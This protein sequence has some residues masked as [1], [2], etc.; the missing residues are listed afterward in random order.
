VDKFYLIDGSGFIFRAYHALPP[1]QRKDGTPVGA[2]Y[3][4]CN[5]LSKLMTSVD[6]DKILVVF[7]AARKTFRQDI[8]P[9]YKA[10][11]PP[12]PEDLI[13]QFSLIKESCGAFGVSSIE[14]EGFE[15]DD[16]IASLA[17][18]ALAESKQVI[19]VSSD[20]DLMQLVNDNVSLLD[21]IKNKA[22]H[23]DEV[24]E[25]F[26]VPPQ[27]VIDVQALAGDSSDNV[28]GVA[29]IGIKTAAQLI[30]EFG[31]L[32]HLYDNLDHVKQPKR[33]ETLAMDRE[34]AFISKQLVTLKNDIR[35]NIIIDQC[36]ID[37]SN[38]KKRDDF[39][40]EQGFSSLINR[41]N[42][43]YTEDKKEQTDQK[44]APHFKL[45]PP[46][47]VD[48]TEKLEDIFK[49]LS[50][51]RAFAFDTETTSLNTFEA[52]LVGIS[53]YVPEKSYYIP[54]GHVFG[55]QLKKD[56][57][58]HVLK[59]V[60]DDK[61]ILKIAHNLKYDQAI[62]R[63]FGID[64]DTYDDTLLMSYALS[65]N[66]HF[67]NLDTLCEI[68]LH[69]K[70]ITFK[71]IVGEGKNKKTFDQ[72]DIQQ[73][74]HYACE[75]AQTAFA[76]WEIFTKTLHQTKQNLLYQR[77]EKDM[78]YITSAMEY[79][80]ILMDEN[81]LDQL[82][83]EFKTQIEHLEKIIHQKAE[84]EFNIASPKQLG[85]VL[86][87]D[88]KLPGA[89]KTKSGTYSTDNDVLEKLSN[90]GHDIPK[91]I[92]EWR[93]LSKLQTTYI[94][95]LKEAIN[96]DTKRVH[97]SYALTSTSTGRFSSSNPNLQN[98]P[99]RTEDGKKIRAAFIAKPGCKLISFDYSQIELRLLAHIAN[100]ETLKD[101]FK[102]GLDIHQATA[103][104]I[105]DTP[106][107]DVTKEQRYK[108][109]AVNFGIIY[110]ISAFGLAK[111]LNCSNGE[112]ASIIQRYFSTYPGIVEYM[113]KQKT[114]AKE[115]GY[116]ET[117]FKR[118]CYTPDINN[119]NHGLQQFSERQAI[120][121]PLQG[122]CADIIKLAMTKTF[123]FLRENKLQSQL[124]LTVH[125]E[126]IFECPI[127]EIDII[128]KEIKNIMEH[129]T[130]L[131][132][133]LLV[134]TT[135]GDSWGDL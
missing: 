112:A 109:K 90:D 28:P 101:A 83:I 49:T 6:H 62:L 14:M 37:L 48:T 10:H 52:D 127:N 19:I 125:D 88:L 123:H 130:T 72:I 96:K 77:I 56:N 128:Q 86:F 57:V 135:M 8:Y 51:S 11:R 87:D 39:L 89:K 27:K 119:K 73:A 15:A 65:G 64:I 13:P 55:K 47:I 58:F 21:P 124:L 92:Q 1:F 80:G 16:L 126:L 114:F 85:E 59:P 99:V 30:N 38:P 45:I 50:S 79:T 132:V 68:Y 134:D 131:S 100:I 61:S 106:L 70:T 108:A 53:F 116:V 18:Q 84:K 5:M 7:D 113:E 82:G 103:S 121:A 60:F 29:G 40:F 41:L 74:S 133:P 97:T 69:H 26:G 111:Q 120:N 71:D 67:H 33:R 95:G 93:A 46:I 31:S 36:S 115:K 25:K 42:N 66:K 78:A 2:V 76:L 4:F 35:T 98:I 75:D 81:I 110:G 105:Y 23:Y 9:E 22:I 44:N 104:S 12:T 91:L 63:K 129:V 20:K 54:V 34:K 43:T 102:N 122:T 32:E 3:G 17:Q 118:R 24:M 117:L 94:D 107:N